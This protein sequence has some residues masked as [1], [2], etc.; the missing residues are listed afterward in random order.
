MINCRVELVVCALQAMDNPLLL[1]KV[2]VIGGGQRVGLDAIPAPCP[3]THITPLIRIPRPLDT[4]HMHS[5]GCSLK[6]C[7]AMQM[8]G[9]EWKVSEFIII[10]I[11]HQVQN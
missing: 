3:L 7:S 8:F 10:I 6:L 5:S 9:T 11:H 2:W 4:K 1:V